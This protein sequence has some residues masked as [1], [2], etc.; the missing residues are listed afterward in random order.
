MANT[1]TQ[2]YIQAVFAVQNRVCLL[3]EE[4]RDNLYKYITGIVTNQRHKLIIIN[5]VSDHIHMFIGMKPVQSLSDLMQDIKGDSS[6]WINN[7][8]L[9]NGKF[10]WQAGYGAFSYSLSQIDQVCKYIANQEAHHKKKTFTEEYKKLLQEFNIDFDEKY[11][12][13]EVV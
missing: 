11:I 7:N 10:E 13:K 2:I 1:Y 3:R 6:K 9:V 4:W 5:G 12:F 8:H